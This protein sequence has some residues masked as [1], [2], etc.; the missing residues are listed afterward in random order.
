MFAGK[1]TENGWERRTNR[2]IISL[3]NE[4]CITI[5]VKMQ[6]IRWIRTCRKNACLKN[7]STQKDYR[8]KKRIQTEKQMV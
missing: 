6:M 7:G 8:S 4:P 2:E 3:F 5:F 1:K